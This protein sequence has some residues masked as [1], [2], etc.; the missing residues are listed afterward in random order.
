MN[1][2]ARQPKTEILILGSGFAGL[3]TALDLE[4]RLGK[5]DSV[6]ITVVNRE[7]Y[8][9][10]TPMLH[11]VAFA[12][13]SVTSVVTPIRQL[14]KRSTFLQGDVTAIDVEKKLVSV[15]Q[16]SSQECS[17]LTYDY[18]MI[19][20]G[21]VTN[22]FGMKSIEET[23]LQ[24]KTLGDAILLRNALLSSLEEAEF[25]AVT[26][27]DTPLLTYLVAGAGFAGVETVAALN[28]FVREAIVYYPHLNENLIKIVL[29]D[30][31][32]QVLPEL[33][34]ELGEYTHKKLLER[35]VDVRMRTKI[36]GRSDRGVE[37]EDGTFLKTAVTIW[38]AGV[39]P[40]PLIKTLG[41]ECDRGKLKVDQY[42]E[43]PGH[44]GVYAT[45][46]CALIMD[47]A[48]GKP[49][50]PTAQHATREAKVVAHN[51]IVAITKRG[52]K[53]E[54]SYQS[55]GQMAA[56]G[57]QTGVAQVFGLKFSGFFAW[58][59]WRMVYL[60]KLPGADRQ[61]RVALN[62][63]LDFFFPKDFV[64]FMSPG[65]TVPTC[66]IEN[67]PK[68]NLAADKVPTTH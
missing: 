27:R 58:M 25:Y 12:D 35:K 19:G 43:V 59:M 15:A 30:M 65:K 24:M 63:I 45:G 62:W 68:E 31:I 6:N 11:E 9:L 2:M 38:T 54:F 1:T 46:D 5:N 3:Y 53:K 55:M 57:K 4:K 51:M 21:S 34:E 14:L 10:F 64:Q 42:L 18:L 39:T 67:S 29:A 47:P 49:C 16:S 40:N 20:L 33:G 23:S 56:I 7:N 44:S 32:P 8:L 36:V 22:F 48:T 26:G 66:A 52:E 41:L 28:D 50:P 17:N 13:V 61:L 60:A 37:F